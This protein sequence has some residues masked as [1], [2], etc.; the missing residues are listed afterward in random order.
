MQSVENSFMIK[1][2]VM[3]KL[4]YSELGYLEDVRA[5]DLE[6]QVRLHTT[7]TH[8]HS[9]TLMRTTR[10]YAHSQHLHTTRTHA[11]SCAQHVHMLTHNTC[12]QHAHM[13]T[14]NTC[15]YKSMQYMHT[16]T[17]AHSTH[18]H[19]MHTCTKP[20]RGQQTV[21]SLIR[22]THVMMTTTPQPPF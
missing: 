7:R 5:W 4:L 11:H 21:K 6:Q 18:T 22:Y 12:T 3:E 20:C 14:H 2:L 16:C 9:C 8:A 19:Y 13:H 15:T 10:T 17:L 1:K